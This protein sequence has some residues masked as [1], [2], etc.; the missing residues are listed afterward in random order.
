MSHST[1]LEKAKRSVSAAQSRLV[2]KSGDVQT[3]RLIRYHESLI[4]QSIERLEGIGD[5]LESSQG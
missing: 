4:L 2:A 3:Q 1:L 5:T